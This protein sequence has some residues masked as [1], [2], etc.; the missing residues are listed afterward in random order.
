[1]NIYIY[2]SANFKKQMHNA[3]DH[4]NVKFR[5]D[6]HSK[7]EDVD[8]LSI[9]KMA[10]QDNP[11]DIYLIDQEKIIDSK[12]LA[13]KIGFLR[14]K[15]AIEKAFLEEHGIWD[16]AV[17]SIDDIGRHIVKKLEN[18]HLNDLEIDEKSLIVKEKNQVNMV[19]P[20]LEGIDSVKTQLEEIDSIDDDQVFLAEDMEA[21]SSIDNA[22]EDE[23]QPPKNYPN[24]DIDDELNGLLVF[25]ENE[26]EKSNINE[27]NYDD[28]ILDFTF[29][30][31]QA[32][33]ATNNQ[34]DTQMALDNDIFSV[35]DSITEEQMKMALE[36]VPVSAISKP[37]SIQ[38]PAYDV[39]KVQEEQKA[40][41][42]YATS[43]AGFSTNLGD[44]GAL[45]SELLKNKTIEISIK[46]K[47]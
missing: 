40:T 21:I 32:F 27:K 45:I 3:L 44:I 33:T 1:M 8:S 29:E 37:T 20:T 4:A 26:E 17:D 7:I 15:D 34:E 18:L 25:D 36:D 14:P 12:S 41:L 9:L 16:I 23:I 19:Q 6:N 38:T 47:D 46:I 28:D 24:F 10:I 13:A 5:L 35:L 43:S 11:D 30:P 39:P 31:T 22:D 42:N 2:G